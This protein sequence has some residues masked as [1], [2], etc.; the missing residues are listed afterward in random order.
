MKTN[1][2]NPQEISETYYDEYGSLAYEKLQKEV[3]K[4][5]NQFN[6]MGYTSEE[7]AEHKLLKEALKILK[8]YE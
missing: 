6:M 8:D 4:M 1:K 2:M 3:Q 7:L 5:N